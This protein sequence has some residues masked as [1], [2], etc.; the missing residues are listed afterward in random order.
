MT[1]L[2]PNFESA[3]SLRR[4]VLGHR[5]HHRRPRHAPSAA[6][7]SEAV[8]RPTGESVW[9][10]VVSCKML[11]ILGLL[12]QVVRNGGLERGEC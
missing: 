3:V 7:V 8:V 4:E 11:D 6:I 10:V 1:S 9:A 2:G 5:R 12:S